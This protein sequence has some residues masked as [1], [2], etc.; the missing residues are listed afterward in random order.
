MLRKEHFNYYFGRLLFLKHDQRWIT[1]KS[2][3]T[4]STESFVSWTLSILLTNVKGLWL[5]SWVVKCS[6][7]A[8]Y[9]LL[10][11]RPIFLSLLGTAILKLILKA[12]LVSKA[13]FQDTIVLLMTKELIKPQSW[14]RSNALTRISLVPSQLMSFHVMKIILFIQND[15]NNSW[16][17]LCSL[18][19]NEKR[20]RYGTEC[21]IK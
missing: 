8:I 12:N 11:Y 9:H 17:F 2:Q 3:K 19:F 15:S 20:G 14:S 10:N 7:K 6:N 21:P 13:L 4:N 16:L 1:Y 18:Q 5:A